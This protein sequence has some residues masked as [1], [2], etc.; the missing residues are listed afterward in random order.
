MAVEVDR[1]SCIRCG[2]CVEQCPLDCLRLDSEGFP[3]MKYNEC[4]YCGVCEMECTVQAIKI[5]L[6]YLI[7]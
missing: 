6:P 4:W 5:K 1:S 3:V 7:R 2:L